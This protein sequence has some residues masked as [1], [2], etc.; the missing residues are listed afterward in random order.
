MSIKEI[1]HKHFWLIIFTLLLLVL[2]VLLSWFIVDIESLYQS[3]ALRPTRGF[4]R[5]YIPEQLSNP[6]QIQSWMTF[7][8]INH[9]FS[10]PPNYLSTSLTI[11][12]NRYPNL[13]ISRY[14]KNKN[15]NDADF[16]KQVQ[17]SVNQYLQSVH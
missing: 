12:D 11:Q 16:L 10:L 7:S 13:T 9:I 14:A 15:L 3:G 6:T 4:H 5:I 17:S 8:Y 2:I 1:F